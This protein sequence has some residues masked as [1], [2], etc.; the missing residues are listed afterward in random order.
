MTYSSDGVCIGLLL[1]FY[2]STVIALRWTPKKSTVTQYDPPH[3]VSPA[4]AAYLRDNGRCER[5]FAAALVSL[6]SK[7]Y[8]R[9]RQHED[10][11]T[12]E[13][14]REA[15]SSLPPEESIILMAL[16]YPPSIH[17]YKFNSRECTWLSQAYDKFGKTMDEEV[18]AGL[19]SAHSLV[20]FSG[21]IYS[22]L[23]LAYLF[24]SAPVF[25]EIASP[26]SIVYLSIFIFMG[27]S[28]FVA[29]VRAW[30]PHSRA[31][32]RRFAAHCAHRIVAA[33]FWLSRRAHVS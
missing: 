3:G 22:V 4:L 1:I 30:P 26:A 12:L 17:T 25:S 18:A 24:Q 28:A 9:I 16:F 11:F 23:A 21:I 5:A 10:W 20:W 7:G 14:L 27:S 15:D 19:M 2:L 13:R 6:A 31:R 32:L 33:G 29:A 8:L